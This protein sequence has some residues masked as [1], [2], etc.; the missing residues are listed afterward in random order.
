MG[1]FGKKKRGEEFDEVPELPDLPGDDDFR[2]PALSSDIASPPG[3]EEVEV[4]SL[5]SLPEYGSEDRFRQNEIKNAIIRPEV[6]RAPLKLLPKAGLSLIEAP[7]SRSIEMSELIKRTKKAEPIYVR[8]DKFETTVQAFEGIRSRIMEIE[9]L[10]NKIRDVKSQE[11]KEL[12]EWENEIQI[13]K[14]RIEAIDRD[15]FGKLD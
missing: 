15:V 4:N 11:E 6:R 14:A 7:A 9:E 12:V 13:I 8:L 5:P 10:L 2:M 1:L 3:L